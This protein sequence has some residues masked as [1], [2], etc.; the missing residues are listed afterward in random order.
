MDLKCPGSGE[1]AR[2]LWSNLEHLTAARRSEVRDRRPRRLR[3]GARRDAAPRACRARQRGADELR[4]WTTAKP[5]LLAGWILADRLPVRMQLQMHKHIWAPTRAASSRT[6][7]PGAHLTGAR[8][9]L[10]FKCRRA[11]AIIAPRITVSER[12]PC[13]R[14]SR[15]VAIN[16]GPKIR[17]TRRSASNAGSNSKRSAHHAKR[18]SASAR[19]FV[20]NAAF[21]SLSPSGRRHPRARR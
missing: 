21:Q 9:P 11:D 16:A 4:L 12:G 20:K 10:G 6:S 1:S 13:F 7:F 14:K 5:A 19:A 15:C 2:N 17:S 18:P 3:M 8:F